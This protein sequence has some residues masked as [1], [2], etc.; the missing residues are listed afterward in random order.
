MLGAPADRQTI[1]L[2]CLNSPQRDSVFCARARARAADLCAARPRIS[3]DMGFTRCACVP[4]SACVFSNVLYAPCTLQYLCASLPVCYLLLA[5][6]H[7]HSPPRNPCAW[8]LSTASAGTLV[9]R[10]CLV[11]MAGS[12]L[13]SRR[14]WSFREPVFVNACAVKPAGREIW[15]ACP[16]WHRCRYGSYVDACIRCRDMIADRCTIL[17][18]VI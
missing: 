18:C 4:A 6:S 8:P 3:F 11:P 7:T 5:T 14:L 15:L 12:F 1:I 2:V 13:R 16:D 9:R 10:L 17:C